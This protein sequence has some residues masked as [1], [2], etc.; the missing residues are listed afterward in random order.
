M[1][2]VKQDLLNTKEISYTLLQI[3]QQ[4]INK[5]L[6]DLANLLEDNITNIIY[7]NKLDLVKMSK[8]D[9]KYDRLE[10]NEIRIRSL[11]HD[12]RKVSELESPLNKVLEFREL[13][14]GLKLEK[15]T[16]PLGV[17]AV[18]YEARPNVTIDVFSLC[19]KSGNVS[20]L[21]GG[22]DA[23]ETNNYLV[24]L[25]KQSLINNGLDSNLIYLMPPEREAIYELLNA[26]GVID[27][28]IPR[29]SQSLIN[30]VRENAKIPVIETGAGIVHTYIDE[31]VNL[32]F[33]SEI[34]Y[35]AKTRRVSVCNALDCII[36]HENKLNDLPKIV[37]K[38]SEKNVIIY[39]DQKSFDELKNNYPKH[40]L[41]MADDTSFGCEFLDYKISIKTVNSIDHAIKHIMKYTSG[42][43]EAIVAEDGNAITKFLNMVDAAVVYVNTSTAFTDGGEFGMGAEIGISTQKLHARG[44]MSISELTSYKWIVYGNG[45]IR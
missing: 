38:L 28:C 22:T 13:P 24:S 35:N 30:F 31:S 33:A 11:S 36:I 12:L 1:K 4:H 29:G 43:S 26:V 41:Y 16:V 27:V 14:N 6:L 37:N 7:Y 2:S 15:K 21:K 20:V 25:I 32:E 5:I 44:P 34:I 40:L 17:V 10:L 8:D 42:H 45:Q 18:I 19:L 39:A 23:W 3:N 9:P